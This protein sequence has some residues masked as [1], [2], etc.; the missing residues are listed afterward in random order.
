[1]KLV[2]LDDRHLLARYF[3]QDIF[4]HMYSLG[5]LDDFYWPRTAYFGFQTEKAV[6]KVSLLYRSEA[7][8]ILLSL[9]NRVF[10]KD[11]VNQLIHFLP[12]QFYAHLSPS[13]EKVF[14]ETYTITDHGGHYKMGLT[15][16]SRIENNP[17][18]NTHL[19]SEND[20]EEIK[21][22]YHIS[23]P[24]NSFDPRM[25]STG[26]YFGYRKSGKLLSIGGIHVYSTVYRVAALG[27]ITTHPEYRNQ[28][29]GRAITTKICH[30][31]GEKVDVIGLNVK[32]NNKAALS[33]YCSLGFKILAEY[34]EF[35][36]KKRL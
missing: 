30:S 12:T 21:D 2:R 28:G 13:L 22:L 18:E 5:D 8:P 25:L 15:D 7:L 27:N 16:Y 19:L 14:S 4:L 17:I 24:G 31:L 10:D 3:R 32:Q 34:G 11:Y 35:T 36:L 1:M 20:L 9:S 26:Q 6:D 29:L 33:L 23:Y